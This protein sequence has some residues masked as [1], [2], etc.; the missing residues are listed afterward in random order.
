MEKINLAYRRK[1]DQLDGVLLIKTVDVR[2]SSKDRK[3]VV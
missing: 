3:S 2:K 1:E